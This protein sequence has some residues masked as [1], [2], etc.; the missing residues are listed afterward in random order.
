MAS[1]P[2][3]LSGEAR[4]AGQIP[5]PAIAT[6]T[7]KFAPSMPFYGKVHAVPVIGTVEHSG[8]LAETVYR[9]FELLVAAVG[10]LVAVPLMLIVAGLVRYDS[11]GPA[12]FYHRR[13][14]RSAIRYGRDLRGRADLVPPPGGYQADVAYYVPRYF[15]LVKF[16]TMWSDAP[17]R[18][19]ELYDFKCNPGEFHQ[20]NFK[21]EDDPRVTRVGRLLRKTSVDEL[22]NLWSVLVGDMRLVGPRPEA[23][24]ILP[25]Y[26]PQE[27]Y[28]FSCKPGVTGLAQINGRNTLNWGEMLRWDLEYVRTR[29]VAGDLKIILLT[30]KRVITRR[31]AF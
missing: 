4:I 12:L 3:V 25:L 18:F 23:P 30:A 26:S 29:S 2:N 7:T 31:G 5:L 13:P 22:P 21:V 28:R 20:R 14:A 1:S 15:T 19:P 24:D 16:R 8:P 17:K 11:P 10:L 27:M 9:G 6:D